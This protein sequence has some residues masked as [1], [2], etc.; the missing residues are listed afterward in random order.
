MTR[1][2]G[3]HGSKRRV[4]VVIN[5]HADGVR[6]AFRRVS[7]AALPQHEFIPP[8][9]LPDPLLLTGTFEGDIADPGR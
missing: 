5:L 6:S 1:E 9:V 2:E 8:S 3:Y 7:G 4:I